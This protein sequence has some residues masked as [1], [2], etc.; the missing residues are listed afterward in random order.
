MRSAIL[1]LAFLLATPS[2]AAILEVGP[3]SLY[4]TLPQA[5]AAAQNGDTVLIHAGF[6]TE[7]AQWNASNL[8]IKNAP[9]TPA[10]AVIV[11]GGTVAGKGLFVTRGNNIVVEG[12]R[13]ENAKVPSG[14]GA[15]IRGEG[16][17]LTVRNSQFIG[18]E[19]GILVT[20]RTAG[21]TL[22]VD[23]SFFDATRSQRPGSL[24]HS[25]YANYV[26]NVIVRNSVFQRD[27]TGHYIKSRALSTIV[28]NTVI[29]DTH[30]TASYLIDI[31]QGG[32]AR[33]VEN[34]LT[35]GASASNCCTAIAYG[36]ETHK[37]GAFVN[38]P[39][40]MLVSHNIFTNLRNSTVGFVVNETTPSQ[41]AILEDNIIQAVRG[42]VIPLQGPGA[43]I[44]T[45]ARPATVPPATVPPV[46]PAGAGSAT[47]ALEMTALLNDLSQRP[48]AAGNNSA[49]PDVLAGLH[50]QDVE[51][52]AVPEP[53]LFGPMLLALAMLGMLRRRLF[54]RRVNAFGRHIVAE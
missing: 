44:N 38:P 14:N 50:I 43:V 11:S 42:R 46:T 32:S 25:L 31:A 49:A 30:G 26:D 54:S 35:K 13:F 8:T 22:I 19:N 4:R 27:Y 15:G 41:P 51:A 29:D 33:I 2:Y 52:Q 53:A 10:G 17:N 45:P 7:G 1:S 34:T 39:G 5:A 21:G 24:G 36:F 23:N 37:G 47:P 48:P 18:N 20:S 40:R 28:S 6:Y 16:Y 12:I 3:Q 9:D